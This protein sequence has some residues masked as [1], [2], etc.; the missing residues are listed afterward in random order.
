[1]KALRYEGLNKVALTDLPVPV[2]SDGEVLVAVEVC[3]L[4]GSDILKIDSDIRG[5]DVPLGHELAGRIELLG[6]GVKGF[7]R[8][9]RVVVAHHVPCGDCHYCRKGSPS[10]CREFKQTNLDPGG[11]AEYVRVSARHVENVMFKV[12]AK[13][14]ASQAALTEPLACCLRNIRRLGLGEG[15]TAVV[16]GLGFIGLLT[17]LALKRLGVTVVGLDTDPSR[18]KLALKLGLVHAYTGRENRT[19]AVISQLSQGR[20]ADALVV[21]AGPAAL[22]PQRLAWVR[23]GGVVNLFAGFNKQPPAHLDLDQLYHRE[24]TLLSSYSPAL[25]DLREAHRLICSGELD[26][27]PFVKSTFGLDRFDEALRQVRGRE[28][29]KAMLLPHKHGSGRP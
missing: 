17:S 9:D 4:C 10:M 5:R 2:V 6:P 1:M 24:I 12:P 11:F 20:G 14:S 21:T 15:D 22:V 8:G 7:K 26:V 13:V 25:E 18:V 29:V 23:D 3:G 28:I 27:S 19:E 16:V